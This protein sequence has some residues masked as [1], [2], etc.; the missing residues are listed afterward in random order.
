M[1]D[2]DQEDVQTHWDERYAEK[3]RIWSGRVNAQLAAVA[4]PLIP[5]RALDLGCGEGGDVVTGDGV[6]GHHRR[7]HIHQQ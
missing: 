6:D 1:S 4:E 2:H 3:G 5:G 7:G